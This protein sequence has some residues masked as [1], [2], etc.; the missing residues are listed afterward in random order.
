[1]KESRRQTLKYLPESVT[2][3]EV[4]ELIGARNSRKAIARRVLKMSSLLLADLFALSVMLIFIPWPLAIMLA[5][6]LLIW[7]INKWY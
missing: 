5:A 2:R 6:A 3:D 1:M 4:L 7:G